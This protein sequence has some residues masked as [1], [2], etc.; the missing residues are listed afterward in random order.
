MK[1]KKKAKEH[2]Y[3]TRRLKEAKARRQISRDTALQL[4][5]IKFDRTPRSRKRFSQVQGARL[6]MLGEKLRMRL[7]IR[8]K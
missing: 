4:L 8:V 7:A 2:Y 1:E 6:K 5:K 3:V